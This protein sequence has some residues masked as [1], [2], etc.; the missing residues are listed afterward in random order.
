MGDV[1]VV[2]GLLVGKSM[3]NEA[4]LKWVEYLESGRFEQGKGYMRNTQDG[5]TT[6]CCLGVAQQCALDHG[7]EFE[8]RWCSTASLPKEVSEWLGI[9]SSDAGSLADCNDGIGRVGSVKSTFPEIA[10]MIRYGL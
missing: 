2:A 9:K 8:P 3:T 5:R 7:V 4:R 10:M 6:W 1:Q